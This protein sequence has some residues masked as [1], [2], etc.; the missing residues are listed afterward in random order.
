MV[1]QEPLLR[2]REGL[3]SR[4]FS[5]SCGLLQAPAGAALVAESAG[6]VVLLPGGVPGALGGGKKVCGCAGASEVRE[7]DFGMSARISWSRTCVQ[8]R[9]DVKKIAHSGLIFTVPVYCFLFMPRLYR[10]R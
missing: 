7:G 6:G 10:Q 5:S 8:K 9:T 1:D 4:H 3:A 2:R